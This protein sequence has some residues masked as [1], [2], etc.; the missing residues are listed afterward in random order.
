MMLGVRR[1][2]AK[3]SETFELAPLVG[4]LFVAAQ[5]EAIAFRHDYIGTEHVLLALLGRDDETGRTLRGLGLE[6]A[7]VRDDTRRIVGDGPAQEAAFDAE[8]LGAI[9]IDLQAVRQKV[10][11]TFGEGALERASRRRGSCGGAGFGVAPRLKRALE[12]A[13]QVAARRGTPLSA[14]DVALGLAQQRDSVAA[15][16]LDV[17]AISPERLR[18]ALGGSRDACG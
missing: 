14:A 2:R 1:R 8:A 17:H 18:A 10:E 6:L 5:D 12:S 9:G 16:I 15:R 4:Q 3:L 11:A 7:G 13:R